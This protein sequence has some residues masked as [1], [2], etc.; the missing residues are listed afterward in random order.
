MA[1]KMA[2]SEERLPHKVLPTDR[3]SEGRVRREQTVLGLGA[4]DP[5]ADAQ[6][7]IT[8]SDP[9][10]GVAYVLEPNTRTAR[11]GRNIS[12]ERRG[13]V[14]AVQVEKLRTAELQAR[15]MIG[16]PPPPPPPPPPPGARGTPSPETRRN[17]A[18]W[19][20]LL[21]ARQ[22]E[23]TVNGVGSSSQV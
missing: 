10:A 16:E 15:K 6:P 20:E 11:R 19:P 23:G 18:N 12:I 14:N 5:S 4:L 22:I 13:D 3:D 9:V 1:L 21:G 7:M 17:I 8:I 2:T